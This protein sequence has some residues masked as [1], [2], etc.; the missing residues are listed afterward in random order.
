MTKTRLNK[1]L[2]ALLGSEELV[3]IWWN[4]SNKAFYGNT[5]EEEYKKDPGHVIEYITY[6]LST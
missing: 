5:P 2:E 3:D 6:Y 1:L 4:S